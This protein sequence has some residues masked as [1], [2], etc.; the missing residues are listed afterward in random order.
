MFKTFTNYK[1]RN[2]FANFFFYL[3][4]Y[5][6]RYFATIFKENEKNNSKTIHN[7]VNSK[8]VKIYLEPVN[9]KYHGKLYIKIS[10][11]CK[12]ATI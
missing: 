5:A 4:L 1:L 10:L 8:F 11:A 2:F 9:L 7:S 6:K 12:P 3:F